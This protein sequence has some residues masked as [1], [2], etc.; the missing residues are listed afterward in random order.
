MYEVVLA[1][2]KKVVF[3]G[4]KQECEKFVL[5]KAEVLS[6][7]MSIYRT[8]TI[9]EDEYYDVTQIYIIREAK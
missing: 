2:E 7:G 3:T 1:Y 8:W 4:S 9:G 6:N 5:S